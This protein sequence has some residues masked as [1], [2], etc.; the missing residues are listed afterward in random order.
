MHSKAR[1]SSLLPGCGEDQTRAKG[2]KDIGHLR[3]VDKK[4]KG[5]TND[6]VALYLLLDMQIC[7]SE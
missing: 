4:K 1:E 7:I 3:Q 5:Y 6:S 2:R